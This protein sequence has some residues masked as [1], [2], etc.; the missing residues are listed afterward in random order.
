VA[1]PGEVPLLSIEEYRPMSPRKV[2][3]YLG[4]KEG[5]LHTR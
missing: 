1:M 2:A 4:G 5:S 3:C